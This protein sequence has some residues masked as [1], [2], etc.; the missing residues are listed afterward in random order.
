MENPMSLNY[1]AEKLF[2]AVES[3]ALD[4]RPLRARLHQAY[5]ES[6]SK[7]RLF[8][9]QLPDEERQLFD[10]IHDEMTR[11]Q[12]QGDEGSITAS[13]QRMSEDDAARL[14]R[15]IIMLLQMVTWELAVRQGQ[16]G[17]AERFPY[18]PSEN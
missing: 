15:K 9:D 18:H 7:I 13:V 3:L 4:T 8:A 1:I 2:A 6:V 5:L 16:Q 12:P 17:R 14:V 11:V 10:A